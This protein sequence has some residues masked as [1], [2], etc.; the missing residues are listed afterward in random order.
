M[1][2]ELNLILVVFQTTKDAQGVANGNIVLS[3]PLAHATLSA[4]SL[5]FIV[6]IIQP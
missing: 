5:S 3:Q 2:V 4:S 1:G 6:K